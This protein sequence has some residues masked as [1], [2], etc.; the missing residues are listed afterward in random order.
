MN[1]IY[2]GYDPKEHEAFDVCRRSIVR[3]LKTDA[4]MIVPIVQSE[5]RACGWYSRDADPLASTEFTYTRFLT[6]RLSGYRGW[7]LFMDCDMLVRADI[8]ELFALADN[9][10]A[11]MVVKHDY[12]PTEDLKMDGKRQTVYPRKNWS[13]LM[14]MNTHRCMA[15]DLPTVNGKSGAYLHQFAWLKDEEIGELPVE[16]NWLEGHSDPAIDPKIVHM[17]RGGPWF[18]QWQ[19]VAFADEWRRMNGEVPEPGWTQSVP[20][21]DGYYWYCNEHW[22]DGAPEFVR[23]HQGKLWFIAGGNHTPAQGAYWLKA[24]VPR[25]PGKVSDAA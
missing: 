1:R 22:S 25:F 8:S 3:H 24:D 5:M 16:W 6:P 15:L 17:T 2:I 11:V 18:P 10:K 21:T 13:S 14:L 20:A 19:H 7:S 23:F 12:Q 4:V 9:S